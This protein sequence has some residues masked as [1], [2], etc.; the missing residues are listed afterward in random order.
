MKIIVNGEP[1][2]RFGRPDEGQNLEDFIEE[3][4]EELGKTNRV[5]SNVRIDGDVLTEDHQSIPCRDV[6]E[7]E[8][9][10]STL[11]ELTINSIGELGTY[12]HRF[13][14]RIP[15][16]LENWEDITRE[17]VQQYRE[18]VTEALEATTK[19]L[20]SI[21]ELT[22]IEAEESGRATMIERAQELRSQVQNADPEELRELI[23]DSARAFFE[24]LIETLQSI[25]D[26]FEQRRERLVEKVNQ[27]ETVLDDLRGEV[28]GVVEKAQEQG[29]DVK[30]WFN[31]E[32]VRDMAEDL[33]RVN[34]IINELD[35]AGKLRAYFPHERHEQI[36]T[37]LKELREGIGRLFALLEERD[38]TEIVKVLK[39]E[40]EPY[41]DNAVELFGELAPEEESV[42]GSS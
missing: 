29:E 42:E 13:L 22:N 37:T 5:L 30:D 10:V 9:E 24:N 26:A 2:D 15:E 6:D 19:V 28:R 23:E 36:E 21:D 39:K 27:M 17:R 16:I 7:L 41:L 1:T 12:A 8:F 34:T 25:L 18:Q 14:D 4:N 32:T 40:I 38:P 3:I 20:T 33:T 35:E 11:E 31:L